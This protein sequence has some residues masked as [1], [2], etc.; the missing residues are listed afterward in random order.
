MKGKKWLCGSILLAL[1]V[2]LVACGGGNSKKNESQNGDLSSSNEPADQQEFTYIEI[3][4]MPTADLSLSTDVVSSVMLNNCYEGLYRVGEKNKIE[5]AGA[6]EL[7]EVS[8]DGLTYRFKLRENAKWS[9]GDPVKASDYVFSWQRT[10]SPETKSEY[11]Y[12]FEPVKNAAAITAGEKDKSE[13]GIKAVGDYEL[14]VTLEKPCPYFDYLMAFV[15]FFPLNQKV[16]EEK[17]ADFAK[18]SENSV[19]NGP[20]VFAEFDGPGSDT[21]WAY[22]KND[23]YWDKDKVKLDKINVNVV[24]EAPTALGLFQDGQA[25]DVTLTGELAQQMS[26]DPQYIV[27]MQGGPYYLELNQR[28]ED[29]VFKNEDL[30]KAISYSI[31]REVLTNQIISD[32]SLP[33]KGLT[34]ENMAFNPKTGEDFAKE[35][36]NHVSYNAKKAKEHW[37]KAKKELNIDSLKIDILSSDNDSSK[38]IVEYLQ[39]TIE[40]NLDGV[41][42]EANPVPFTVR[43]DRSNK[44]DFDLVLSGWNADY[45][46][47][48]SFLDL[49]QTGYSYNRGR[50]SNPEYD[51]LVN[52][53]STT[54]ALDPEKRWESML[55]AE[56]LIIGETGVIPVYQKAEAHMRNSK[57]KGVI[58]H[59]TGSRYDYKEAYMTK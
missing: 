28:A 35:T 5:P 37:E 1:S 53:A 41:K 12:L 14:E 40:E 47:P 15:N 24:K 43:L 2:G 52:D 17:G 19:Y 13:L 18:T 20:F 50:Y 48:S 46:D 27:E 7:A 56:D 51:K 54:Y 55:T 6:K 3:Q 29:S 34:P 22:E 25:D 10:V 44:G 38:K 59:S 31:D 8:E 4:E 9:N 26:N 36:T 58:H 49:F 32:G 57:L 33:A 11:A 42:I 39:S 16:V 30:R 21:S 23:Q 45:P